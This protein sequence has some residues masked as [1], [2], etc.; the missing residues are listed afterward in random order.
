[1]K[2]SPSQ[3]IIAAKTE[4]CR[5]PCPE[6]SHQRKKS[7]IPT[8]RITVNPTEILYHCHHCNFE[9]VIPNQPFYEKYQDEQRQPPKVVQIPTQLNKNAEQLAKDESVIRAFFK[10]RGVDISDMSE[11]PPMTAGTRF[12]RDHGDHPAVGFIYGNPDRP[13]AIKWRA[14]DEKLF[15]QQNSAA[16]FY[17]LDRVAPDA[18]ELLIV[19]GEA[20]VIALASI[21]ITAVSCPNGAPEKVS[22]GFVTP[23]E[24]KKFSYVYTSKDVWEK[25]DRIILA[26]DTDSAGNALAEE[27]YRRMD[28][29]KCWR[30]TFPEGCKDPTDVLKKYGSVGLK[31]AIH[32]PEPVPLVGVYPATDYHH[33]LYQMYEEGHGHGESTGYKTVD[34]LF[35]VKEGLCYIVTGMPSSG[36]SEF[37]D[38]IMV[39]LSTMK[40]WKHAVASFE[41]PPHVHIAKLAE[42]V[43]GKPFFEGVM[44]RI[45]R[46][47]LA[48]AEGFINEHFVFLQNKSGDLSTMESILK[49]AKMAICRMG[50]RLL[51]I[52]PYNYIEPESHEESETKQINTMLT[53]L[54]AFAQAYNVAVFFVAHPAKMYA[55]DDG[56]FSIPKGENISGS[57][58]WFSKADVGITVHR[59]SEGVE[60]HTWKMR[61]KWIGKQGM[62]RIAYDIPTGRYF[63]GMPDDQWGVAPKNSDKSRNWQDVDDYG[64][65][66][67]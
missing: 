3:Q 8:L 49:R 19:E 60:I 1:M 9:G 7:T 31:D 39:N 41:N 34:N 58:A 18:K 65:L 33:N 20:D 59:G 42:K 26:V 57:A 54:I 45:T 40:G 64:D 2:L 22:N 15:T 4:S 11:L 12:F 67:F 48:M 53:R 56:S 51:V 23:E 52:D 35:T 28:R 29:A 27:L 66:D 25:V 47:E 38:Q 10:A 6:C 61:F 13:S 63:D 32:R 36:K 62:T 50:I 24:D 43:I 37:I 46:Q 17:G 44:P 30:V 21:G 14:V 16:S 55:R 5:I